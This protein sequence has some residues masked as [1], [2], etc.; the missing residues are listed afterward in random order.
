MWRM[1]VLIAVGAALLFPCS[2]MGATSGAGSSTGLE[3]PRDPDV[4]LKEVL[5]REE[6]K[7]AAEKDLLDRILAWIGE[8]LLRL[9]RWILGS[10]PSLGMGPSEGGLLSKVA[11]WWIIGA[12][13]VALITFGGFVLKRLPL[14]RAWFRREEKPASLKQEAILRSVQAWNQG[15]RLAEQGN[16]PEALLYLF[17]SII[18]LL[19]EKG[20]ITNYSG[21]TNREILQSLPQGEPARAGLAGIVPLFNRVRYGNGRCDKA[22]Y[23]H[24]L[25]LCTKLTERA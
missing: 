13:V 12:L 11:A 21:K 22:E 10:L 9:L 1:L 8:Q 23:E 20:A 25:E 3:L 24:F 16:Y 7:K 17:R 19:A 5:A 18:L 15:V 14:I 6:F 2:C 4:V